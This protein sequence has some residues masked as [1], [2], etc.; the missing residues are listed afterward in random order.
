LLQQNLSVLNWECRLTEA[1]VY[2]GYKTVVVIVV[3]I[4][5]LHS[6]HKNTNDTLRS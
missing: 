4:S 6:H 3:I 2:N 5:A 1:G